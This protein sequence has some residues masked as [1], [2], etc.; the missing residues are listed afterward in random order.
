MRWLIRVFWAEITHILFC[1]DCSA[2]SLPWCRWQLLITS[3]SQCFAVADRVIPRVSVWL[4]GKHT[5]CHGSLLSCEWGQ[6][7][8]TALEAS[9]SLAYPR[10]SCCLL[11][12]SG[13]TGER[14]LSPPWW[15]GCCAWLR[16][17][18]SF[19]IELD[20]EA[21]ASWSSFC[22]P[23]V[24]LLFLLPRSSQNSTCFALPGSSSRLL[25]AHCQQ[26]FISHHR[27]GAAGVTPCLQ[28]L[29]CCILAIS[30]LW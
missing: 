1:V 4:T 19:L 8:P 21:L 20:K 25:H 11:W 29:V 10:L 17:Q 7:Q 14:G 28:C 27:N 18:C 22:F 9:P 24:P 5:S 3:S 23:L 12:L 30:I 15:G 2:L 6:V 13:S 16:L 26:S